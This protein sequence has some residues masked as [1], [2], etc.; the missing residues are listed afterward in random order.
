MINV[1]FRKK[2]TQIIDATVAEVDV[3]ID[4]DHKKG[5]A[6]N[7]KLPKEME[8]LKVFKNLLAKLKE[9]LNARPQNEI[10]ENKQKAEIEELN[11]LVGAVLDQLFAMANAGEITDQK[12]VAAIKSWL[13]ELNMRRRQGSKIMN[14]L[15]EM[16]Q[17]VR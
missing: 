17:K 14:R 1:S 6:P 13:V 2:S 8:L 4:K 10:E 16:R 15:A 5:R 9:K 11:Q 12:L 7:E 3:F